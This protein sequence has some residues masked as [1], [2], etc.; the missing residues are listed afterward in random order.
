MRLSA[1]DLNG[2]A[3]APAPLPPFVEPR[4]G[5]VEEVVL[6]SLGSSRIR[7]H[8]AARIA[9][10]AYPQ[11][12]G[13]HG[14]AVRAL[15]RRGMLIGMTV[16]RTLSAADHARID[17]RMARVLAIVHRAAPPV[18][19]D[20]ELL[21]LLAAARALPLAGADHMLARARIASIG[22]DGVIPPAVAALA[23]ELGEATMPELADRLLPAPRHLE[24]ANFAPPI[25][26]AYMG[27][28]S[29]VGRQ[30]ETSS[31][32]GMRAFRVIVPVEDIELARRSTRRC[33]GATASA[34]RAGATTPTATVS[35]SRAATRS[36]TAIR[37]Y[38]GPATEMST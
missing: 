8:R 13:D 20:A 25:G 6:L 30:P 23:D 15:R 32:E 17:E 37:R 22:E 12:P 16:L 1:S 4:L 9:G 36:P 14:T 10:S 11:G 7:A 2:F 3:R 27:G 21:A 18:G 5:L 35:C 29:G 28:G 31:N 33:W 38:P 24:D 34:S 26:V 19:G